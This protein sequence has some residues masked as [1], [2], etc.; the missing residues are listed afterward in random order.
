MLTQARAKEMCA[1]ASKFPMWGNYTK[2]MTNAEKDFVMQTFR[3][4]PQGSITVSRVVHR[5]AEGVNPLDG[6][7]I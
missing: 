5:I 2:K 1:V 3:D 7:P 4:S 6:S